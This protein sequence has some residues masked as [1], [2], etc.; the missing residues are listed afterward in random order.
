MNS[1]LVQ[2]V[3]NVMWL[4]K[5]SICVSNVSMIMSLLER[6]N[7]KT[8]FCH[9]IFL[10]FWIAQFILLQN[11]IH[12]W[13]DL[14]CFLL[15]WICPNKIIKDINVC[16]NFFTISKKLL[17]FN[18]HISTKKGVL[19]NINKVI[20]NSFWLEKQNKTTG[21]LLNFILTHLQNFQ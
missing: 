5:N 4:T 1:T 6:N 14:N 21:F 8:L 7:N 20:E 12:S 19:R 10:F 2:D 18:C 3:R 16:D 15:F 17:V 13:I 9:P 11:V